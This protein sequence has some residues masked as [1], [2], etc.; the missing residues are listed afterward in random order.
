MSAKSKVIH[1]SLETS[2][3]LKCPVWDDKPPRM[4]SFIQP[5]FCSP[6]ELQL[7]VVY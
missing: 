4:S 3:V 1:L 6:R 2:V 5:D 7:A